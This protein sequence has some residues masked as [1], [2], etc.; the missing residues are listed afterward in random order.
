MKWLKFVIIKGIYNNEII[1]NYEAWV[2]NNENF[3]IMSYKFV[4]MK[5]FDNYVSSLGC[6]CVRELQT[7]ASVWNVAHATTRLS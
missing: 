1:Y 7:P 5:H 3:A 6:Y 4:I 2:F